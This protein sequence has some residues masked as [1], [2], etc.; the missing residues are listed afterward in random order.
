MR[1]QAS[2]D[3]AKA[4]QA[5]NH[6][7]GFS[8]TE[9]IIVLAGVSLLASIAVPIGETALDQYALLMAADQITTQ[10]QAARL[11][12]VSSNET[13]RLRFGPAAGAYR[14]ES[15]AGEVTAGPFFL[16]RGVNWNAADTRSAIS[17]PGSFVA[18]LPTGNL[19]AT[20]DGSAGRVKIVN[21]TNRKI[22]IVVSSGGM[23]SRTPTYRTTS[24]P[25]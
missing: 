4:A 9:L 15:G 17:F 25:F 5:R 18:F 10:L 16:P 14:I 2:A 7:P 23:I 22:D 8:L 6:N 24:P 20:G 11:K 21:Q 3:R 19:P 1:N 12:A 13:F